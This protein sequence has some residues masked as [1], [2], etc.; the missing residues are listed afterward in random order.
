MASGLL[1]PSPCSAQA[2]PRGLL[3]WGYLTLYI[4]ANR[5][6]TRELVQTRARPCGRIAWPVALPASGLFL[7]SALLP[8]PSAGQGGCA[9]ASARSQQAAQAACIHLPPSARAAEG[10]GSPRAARLG[11]GS[12]PVCLHLL[13]LRGEGPSCRCPSSS[14][15]CTGPLRGWATS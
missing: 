15:G 9:Q 3:P 5:A 13:R 6:Q 11:S 4:P 1:T 2:G 12:D 10:R 7:P 8:S 14:T